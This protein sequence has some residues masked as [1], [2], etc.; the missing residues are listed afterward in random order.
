MAALMEL[1]NKILNGSGLIEHV[2]PHNNFIIIARGYQWWGR[3]YPWDFVIIDY[4]LINSVPC[5]ARYYDV[6]VIGVFNRP[7][8]NGFWPYY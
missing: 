4:L 3:L 8:H 5:I 1:I 2:R 6:S 7:I